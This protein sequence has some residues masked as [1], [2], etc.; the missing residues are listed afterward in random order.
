MNV[1][2]FML[3]SVL[4]EGSDDLSQHKKIYG[5]KDLIKI[6]LGHKKSIFAQWGRGDFNESILEETIQRKT[7]AKNLQ[8]T[9]TG[10][11]GKNRFQVFFL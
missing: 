9:F 2:T 8:I 4:N 11:L 7:R 5:I 10:I 1:G 3:V 6:L